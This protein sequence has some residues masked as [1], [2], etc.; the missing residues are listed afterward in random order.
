M[1]LMRREMVYPEKRWHW[2]FH[3]YPR[4]AWSYAFVETNAGIANRLSGHLYITGVPDHG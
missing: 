4:A 1:K 2:A 3:L